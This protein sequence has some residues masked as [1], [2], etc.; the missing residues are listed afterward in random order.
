MAWNRTTLPQTSHRS[1]FK[2]FSNYAKIQLG[3]YRI[4]EKFRLTS[5]YEKKNECLQVKT[6]S[7]F[8]FL[9]KEWPKFKCLN[10]MPWNRSF[11]FKQNCLHKKVVLC[12]WLLR[13]WDCVKSLLTLSLN[14]SWNSEKKKT[15]KATKLITSIYYVI[16]S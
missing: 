3:K 15:K 4:E 6:N 16:C 12:V 13:T 10:C 8:L 1:T 9:C 5:R 11:K 14:C 7:D 2:R